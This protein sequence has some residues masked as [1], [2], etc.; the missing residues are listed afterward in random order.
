VSAKSRK[1]DKNKA[2]AAADDAQPRS[3][4]I[5]YSIAALVALAGLLDA[6]YLTVSHYTG[7]NVLCGESLECDKVLASRYATVFGVP[8]ALFGVLGYFTVFSC[9]TLS[10]FGHLRPRLPL[11]IVVGLMF[12][13][14]LWFLYVQ[15]FI[16][17]AYCRYCLLSAA[18]TFVIAG[19]LLALPPR[20]TTA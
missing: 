17:N 7:Q 12:L 8:V 14:T 6:T 11:A 2:R 16:L 9:A 20:R 18:C 15:A 13:G 3:H 5:L 10:A 19:L 1:R 4:T